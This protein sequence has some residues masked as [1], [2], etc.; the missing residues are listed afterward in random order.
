LGASGFIGRWVAR[1]LSLC[2]ARLSLVVRNR[3]AAERVFAAWGVAGDVVE[4]DLCIAGKLSEL[5]DRLRPTIVFN[6]AGYGVSRTERDERLALDLNGRLVGELCGAVVRTRNPRWDGMDVVHAGSILEYGPIGGD[7]SEG[8]AATPTTLYG[9]SK[10]AGTAALVRGD[11][12]RSI[13][14]LTARL[15]TV[16]GPGEQADRLVP[17]MLEAARTRRP[18]TLTQ[19]TQ[20][21]DFTYV[22]D[23]ADGLLRLGLTPGASGAIVNLATGRLTTVRR[24]VE[25]AARVLKIPRELLQFGAIPTHTDEIEHDPITLTRLRDLIG[26]RP[27]TNITTG[28]RHTL[29]F[30]EKHPDRTHA[31]A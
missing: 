26:W 6:L 31:A 19:G 11:A 7:L 17:S 14:G 15:A 23:V 9:R 12:T 28:I 21:R 24:F 4:A 16:Y 25:V 29:E 2:R 18:L 22:G 8:S 5:I 13:K 1:R 27:S 20:R 3:T 30:V 10:L